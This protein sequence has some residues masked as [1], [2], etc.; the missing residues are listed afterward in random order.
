MFP[1]DERLEPYWGL[2]EEFDIPVAIHLGPG[3]PGAAYESSPSPVKFPAFRMEAGDPLRL[4]NVLLRHKRLRLL[5][6]HAGWP[7]LESMV[8]LLYAHPNVYVDV[9]ALQAMFMVPRP[10]Y[11]EYVKALVDSGFAKRVVF[12]SDFPNQVGPGI[13]A[14]LAGGFLT[15]AQKAD[16]LCGNA[17][18]YLR[19]LWTCMS[20]TGSRCDA[21]CAAAKAAVAAKTSRTSR[22][23]IM[24]IST[25]AT[26]RTA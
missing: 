7:R 22:E 11:Y 9:G 19:L 23:R 4:E 12:G 17:M 20:I 6:M 24:V 21:G 13:D 2:A 25:T 10:S 14:I 16:V 8:A 18:R 26:V 15:D 3:P 1:D 5:V